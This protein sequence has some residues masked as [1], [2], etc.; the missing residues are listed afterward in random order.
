MLFS[1]WAKEVD[2]AL[3]FSLAPDPE[4]PRHRCLSHPTTNK[5]IKIE[6]STFIAWENP[7]PPSWFREVQRISRGDNCVICVE[8]CE[9]SRETWV[10][11]WLMIY[12]RWSGGWREKI[13]FFASWVIL[14]FGN[15]FC[16]CSIWALVRSGLTYRISFSNCV[17]F[18]KP[19]TSVSWLKRRS[20]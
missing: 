16:S 10:S 1:S 19:F 8:I 15:A 7:T 17:S 18:S 12:L 14:H 3:G 4:P 5:P 6:I 11:P 2:D 13:Y 9:I 20:R